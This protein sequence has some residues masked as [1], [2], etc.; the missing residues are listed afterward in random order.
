MKMLSEVKAPP[1]VSISALYMYRRYV[2]EL[3]FDA[4]KTDRNGPRH[5]GHE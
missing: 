1:P 2:K 3:P 5:V 4:S